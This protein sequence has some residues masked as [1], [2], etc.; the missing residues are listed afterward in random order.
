VSRLGRLIL[1]GRQASTGFDTC[2]AD[3]GPLALYLISGRERKKE[4]VV[5]GH[6]CQIDTEPD[7]ESAQNGAI[8]AI[9]AVTIGL[10]PLTGTVWGHETAVS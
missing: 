1:K 8:V 9:L 3:S 7:Q 5:Y 10:A 4:G 2:G 6:S